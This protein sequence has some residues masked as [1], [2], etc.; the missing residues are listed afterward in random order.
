MSS[1][2]ERGWR[3]DS[4]WA[5]HPPSLA[6]AGFGDQEASAGKAAEGRVP[7]VAERENAPTLPMRSI[8]VP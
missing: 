2:L 7:V 4:S 1:G 5:Y 3:F 8:F 6:K